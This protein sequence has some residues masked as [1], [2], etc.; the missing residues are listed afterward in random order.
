[1]WLVMVLIGLLLLMSLIVMI[2]VFTALISASLPDT[3]EIMNAAFRIGFLATPI[4]WMVDRVS[5]IDAS[6]DVVRFY[7]EFNPFYHM[8]EVVRGPILGSDY[9]HSIFVVFCMIIL[10]TIINSIIY[11]KQKNL[12][13]MSY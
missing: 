7:V 5:V 4:I 2:S 13:E 6:R 11:K 8:I 10:L 9:Q 3:K 12:M 1:M